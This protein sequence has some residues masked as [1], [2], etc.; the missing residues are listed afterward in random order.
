MTHASA[1]SAFAFLG[2]LNDRSRDGSEAAK[3]ALSALLPAAAPALV[4]LVEGG[5]S[6]TAG[7]GGAAAAA[8]DADA[9]ATL[10]GDVCDALFSVRDS[11]ASSS[12]TDAPLRARVS[13]R[14]GGDRG[15]MPSDARCS[16]ERDP[17]RFPKQKE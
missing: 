15:A 12:D 9:A 4:A 13:R 7:C 11:K 2:A 10:L 5:D 8:V 14:G 6:E 3:A 17:G 1:S 16:H